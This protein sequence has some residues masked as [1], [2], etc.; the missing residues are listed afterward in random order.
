[1]NEKLKKITEAFREP[2]LLFLIT[3]FMFVS[4]VSPSAKTVFTA[5]LIVA[6]L[7]FTAFRHLFFQQFR[8]PIVIVACGLYLLLLLA[9]LWSPATGSQKFLVLNKYSKLL[10]LPVLM[11]AFSS[12]KNRKAG[13]VA[14]LTAIFIT[15]VLALMQK[16][17]WVNLH[18]NGLADPAFVFQS[19]IMTSFL[20]AFAAYVSFCIYLGRSELS[21]H[22]LYL[23]LT[24]F[25]SYSV[26]FVNIGRTGYF[27]YLLLAVFFCFQYFSLKRALLAGLVCFAAFSLLYSQSPLMKSNI[28]QLVSSYQH[29]KEKKKDTSLGFRIQFH[30]FA[31]SLVKK[32]PWFG[33][34]TGSFAYWY[35]K[36]KPVKNWNEPLREPH[37]EYWMFAVQTGLT[38]LL[39]LLGFFAL[40]FYMASKLKKSSLIAQAVLLAFMAGCLTDSLLFY[41]GPGYF[42]IAFV[43]LFSA[44][45]KRLAEVSQNNTLFSESFQ[46]DNFNSC[47]Y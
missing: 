36:E 17:G 18:G 26:F 33:E 3:A 40:F 24:L 10:F 35:E 37:S 7:G 31:A 47:Q 1:M 25:F 30:Q 5:L 29:F 2:Y 41:G 11:V 9:C 15:A 34:G 12:L 45:Y 28:N 22:W 21:S 16:Y 38:G 46:K 14:F 6:V 44:E 39:A 27:I 43:A 8:Q 20:F 23:L 4:P 19:H 32:S 13:I 42:F